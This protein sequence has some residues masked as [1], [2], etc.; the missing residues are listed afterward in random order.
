MLGSAV[1]LG[2]AKKCYARMCTSP[3]WGWESVCVQW[4]ELSWCAVPCQAREAWCCGVSLLRDIQKPPGAVL[5]Q[6]R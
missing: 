4:V 5:G 3:A 1:L 6:W 2:L